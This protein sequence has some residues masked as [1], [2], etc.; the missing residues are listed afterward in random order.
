MMSGAESVS[1][2]NPSTAR[3]VSGVADAA[4]SGLDSKAPSPPAAALAAAVL[5]T[6]RREIFC[7]PRSFILFAPG[8]DLK[9]KASAVP[10]PKAAKLRIRSAAAVAAHQAGAAGGGWKR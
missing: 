7:G 6:C 5:S 2:M 1:A 4:Y 10:A 9:L 8:F 3:V